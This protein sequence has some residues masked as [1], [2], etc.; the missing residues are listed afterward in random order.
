LLNE[1]SLTAL[2]NSGA[3]SRYQAMVNA[4]R[5]QNIEQPQANLDQATQGTML[6]TWKPYSVTPA[7]VPYGQNTNG[8]VKPTVTGGPSMTPELQQMGG[9][10]AKDAMARQLGGNVNTSTFPSD[11]QLGMTPMPEA[12]MLD[13]ILGYAATGTSL[14][15]AA[16]K[17]GMLGGGAAAPAGAAGST[18]VPATMGTSTIPGAATQAPAAS[19]TSVLDALQSFGGGSPGSGP[20]ARSSYSDMLLKQQLRDFGI[21]QDATYTNSID[22]RQ[23]EP[24]E[25]RSYGGGKRAGWPRTRR[26]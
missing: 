4:G 12:S 18:A 26:A 24:V 22:M 25:G 23:Q 20:A 14:L 15:G 7:S 5:L 9:Q 2:Q 21:G 13:K 10:V 17:M 1:S 11:A 8:A 19:G 6:S 16:G 3:T